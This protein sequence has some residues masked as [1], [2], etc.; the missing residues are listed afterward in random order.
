MAI[1]ILSVSLLGLAQLM[2][3]ALEKHRLAEY[4][5]KGVQVAEGRIEELRNLYNSEIST[6]TPETDLT[7]G[8]HGPETLT[9]AAVSGTA[10][11]TRSFVVAW[12]V[13][14]LAGGQKQ[15]TVTVR[16][17]STNVLESKTISVLAVFAP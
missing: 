5:T 4:T 14:A 16:E 1:I 3:V 11:G 17:P 7:A 9:I 13:T 8:S 15:V 12:D 10:Q 6:A 2:L